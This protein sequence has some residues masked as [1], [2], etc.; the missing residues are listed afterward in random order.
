MKKNKNSNT[1][2]KFLY[3]YAETFYS[4]G[5]DEW[6]N[7]LPGYLAQI[8]LHKFTIVKETPKGA[9]IQEEFHGLHSPKKFV[10]LTARKKFACRTKQD[11]LESFLA[12]KNKHLKILKEKTEKIKGVLAL[13]KRIDIENDNCNVTELCNGSCPLLGSN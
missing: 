13:A 8:H 2:N 11:A 9:W 12:R 5:V 4:T 1:N 6:D 10:L 3:R 7:P